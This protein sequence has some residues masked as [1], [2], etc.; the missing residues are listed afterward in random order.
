MQR[1]KSTL[2]QGPVLR[3]HDRR[4]IFRQT[5]QSG[6]EE[7]DIVQKVREPNG[8]RTKRSILVRQIPAGQWHR[9]GRVESSR[10]NLRHI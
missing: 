1:T 4:L 7:L 8:R 10:F 5:K 2:Q 3:V 9:P 6:V